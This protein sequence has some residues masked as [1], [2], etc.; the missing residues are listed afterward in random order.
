MGHEI[1]CLANIEL[2]L[3]VET[4]VLKFIF[5]CLKKGNVNSYPYWVSYQAFLMCLKH[6]HQNE[7]SVLLLL[8]IHS[9]C[10]KTGNI[11]T[12]SHSEFPTKASFNMF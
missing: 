11:Y 6:Q 8:K 7:T 1:S 12:P 10:F 9:Q 2:T 4:L 5:K 3:V